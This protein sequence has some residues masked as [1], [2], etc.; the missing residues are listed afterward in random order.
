MG[1]HWLAMGR[2]IVLHD[3]T[4]RKQ[5][6]TIQ[7]LDAHGSEPGTLNSTSDVMVMAVLLGI[8]NVSNSVLLRVAL[9][10]PLNCYKLHTS[11]SCV[12][13][14]FHPTLQ[15]KQPIHERPTDTCRICR[16]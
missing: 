1:F 16:W 4:C 13:R 2:N 14:G 10:S 11:S 9:G 15:N 6:Y 5:S 8:G 3:G 7:D 12:S